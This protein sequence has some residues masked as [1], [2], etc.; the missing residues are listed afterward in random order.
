MLIQKFMGTNTSTQLYE[1]KKRVEYI[2]LL[3]TLGEQEDC[4]FFPSLSPLNVWV[5]LKNTPVLLFL[6]FCFI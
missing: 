1:N 4:M 3:F 5:F 6:F 2:V